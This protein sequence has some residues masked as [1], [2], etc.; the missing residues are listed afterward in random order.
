MALPVS[1]ELVAEKQ[2][3]FTLPGKLHLTFDNPGPVQIDPDS[4]SD[5][6]KRWVNE[7]ARAGIL[8]VHNPNKKVE[9]TEKKEEAPEPVE[10]LREGLQFR[11][12][13]ENPERDKLV[14]GI[15]KLL[16]GKVGD[17]KKAIQGSNNILFLRLITE[18]ESKG[19]KRSSVIDAA[20]EQLKELHAKVASIVGASDGDNVNY[21]M[22]DP[23]LRNLPEVEEEPERTITIKPI[24]DSDE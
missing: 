8:K 23:S 5:Q 12:G 4:L 6:E 1:I 19:K 20:N 17:I 24:T 21:F 14:E 16:S 2:P 15:K 11:E 22:P 9:K 13:P 18:L 3:F 10:V 7:G